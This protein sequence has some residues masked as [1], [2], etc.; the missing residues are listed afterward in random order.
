MTGDHGA[1]TTIANEFAVVTVDKI[2]TRNGE[3]LEIASP[4]LGF[5]IQLDPLELESLSWQT[6]ESLSRFLE[7][8]YGP[9]H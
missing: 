4:R 5:R 8:P 9:G 1:A 7:D 3:R 2:F 6:K